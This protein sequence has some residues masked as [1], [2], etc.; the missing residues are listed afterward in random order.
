MKEEKSNEKAYSLYFYRYLCSVLVVIIHVNLFSDVNFTLNYIFVQILTRIAVPSFFLTS[1]YF[2]FEKLK[3]KKV[4]IWKILKK[5]FIVYSFVSI[6][7]IIISIFINK[8]SFLEILTNFFIKGSFYHL[9]YFP[10]LIISI[11]T[12]YLFYKFKLLKFI[13][14][15][16]LFL[17]VF[18]CMGCSY[19]NIFA[20][21][22]L[23]KEVITWEN[24]YI[25]RRIFLMGLPFVSLGFF[26]NNNIER[27]KNLKNS[28]LLISLILIIILFILE[29]A[30]VYILK[31][32][33]NIFVT[34]F[35]Y[36]L[37]AIIFS[38][39]IKIENQ[40]KKFNTLCL[41][42]KESADT[43]YYWHPII[44]IVLND[45]FY[46]IFNF[47]I[48]TII[49]FITTISLCLLISYIVQK[50]KIKNTK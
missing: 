7:Y 49:S 24:F 5:Y 29:I 18:G 26:I 45:V 4:K 30:Y 9:W 12:I 48:P 39:I 32:Q 15:F 10:A 20:E 43:T 8:I 28:K 23:I 27:I 16:S 17:Y 11:L 1:G 46:M 22:P 44:L 13:V 38:I 21:V 50:S 2:L 35:L 3:N 6:P 14:Y 36:P 41:N 40:N 42:L 31:L 19:F 37:V 47:Q 33:I 25:I 34:I